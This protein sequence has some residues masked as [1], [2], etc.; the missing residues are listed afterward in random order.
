MKEQVKIDWQAALASIEKVRLRLDRAEVSAEERERVFRQR[1]EAL[2]HAPAEAADERRRQNAIVFRVDEELFA[3]PLSSVT[4]VLSGAKIAPVPGAPAS[5]AGVI[6]LRGE[7][8]PV[9]DL[10]QLLGAA[11]RQPRE[12]VL[13]VLH[14]SR[15]TGLLVAQVEDIRAVAESDL[16]EAPAANPRIKGITG[17]LIQ[18]LDLGVLLD[19]SA[20]EASS[21]DE[22]LRLRDR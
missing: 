7:I 6:Q 21:A 2:A 22:A 15:E 12:T 3:L 11:A 4:E 18:V 14:E 19:G 13:L 5:V 20:D 10:K 16:R 1:K 8:R 17:D 9:F